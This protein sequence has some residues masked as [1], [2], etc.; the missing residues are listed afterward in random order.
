M[1][2]LVV[3]HLPSLTPLFSTVLQCEGC[4][5]SL[6]LGCLDLPTIGA[7]SILELVTNSGSSRM[8]QA[9]NLYIVTQLFTF[10]YGVSCGKKLHFPSSSFNQ[11]LVVQRLDFH[12]PL[13]KT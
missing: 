13:D 1:E 12:Y 4:L 6:G 8:S 5:A 7:V 3:F 9:P 2:G 10:H 11:A